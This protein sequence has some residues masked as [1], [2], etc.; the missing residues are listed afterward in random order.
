MSPDLLRLAAL[1][2]D[3]LAVLS[4]HVQDAVAKLSEVSWTPTGARFLMPMNRF[5]WEAALARPRRE[6]RRRAVLHV[7]RV[8]RVRVAGAGTA[9]RTQIVS[10]LA[11]MFVPGEAPQGAIEIACSGGVTFRLDVECIEARLSDVGAVWSASM[12]PRHVVP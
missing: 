8:T 2:A 11:L 6:E 9:D 4:A 1:D 10:V 7:D 12:R 5:A 3:D